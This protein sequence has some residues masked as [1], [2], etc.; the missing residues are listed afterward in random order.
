MRRTLKEAPAF[1]AEIENGG[2]DRKKRPLWLRA[3][4]AGGLIFLF[5]ILFW[6]PA[7]AKVYADAAPARSYSI[8]SMNETD[9]V[10]M[11]GDGK[12]YLDDWSGASGQYFRFEKC[13]VGEVNGYRIVSAATGKAMA[14][15]SVYARS[16]VFPT[17]RRNDI[18]QVWLVQYMRNGSVE[19]LCAA[20]RKYVLSIKGG[21]T[22]PGTELVLLKNNHKAYQQWTIAPGT[23]TS[24]TIGS[25]HRT[26]TV[27]AVFTRILPSDDGRIY[28]VALPPYAA[29]PRSG[30]IVASVKAASAVTIKGDLGAGTEA[31]LLQKKFL[32][33]RKFKGFY[34]SI[35]NGFFLT[36]PENAATNQKAF[37]TAA[38]KK[39]L[40]LMLNDP[41]INIAK[42]LRV[43]HAVVDFPIEAFLS[44]DSYS[45]VYEGR[46]YRFSHA[47][48]AGQAEHLRQ[49]HENGVVVTGVFYLTNKTMTDCILPSAVSGSRFQN[50]T[51]CALNTANA[52]RKRLEAL[53]S[54]L[55]EEFT[56]K[57]ILVANWVYGNEENNY[58]VYHYAG[59]VSYFR[60]HDALA[61][62]FRLFN[63]A[64]KSKWKNARTYF[65]LDHNWN[66]WF[67]VPGSYQGMALTADFH[68]D[69]AGEGAVHWD[70]A[71]HPYPSP[72]MDCR[73]WNRTAF[74]TDSGSSGQITMANARAFA[75]YIKK[76]YGK[77]T[78]IIMS[79]TGICALDQDGTNRVNDQAA[80]VALAYYLTEFDSNIDMI[81][82]HREMDEAGSAWHLGLY[83]FDGLAFARSSARPAALVFAYMDTSKWEKYVGK[84]IR[85]TGFKDWPTFVRSFGLTFTESKFKGI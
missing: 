54:C 83:E 77:S 25:N 15:R 33:A 73:F 67:E 48:I 36:N 23:I 80:A 45:Y 22:D 50:A 28:L 69:L 32:L 8:R 20:N 72:E 5:C 13:R 12:F 30:R 2:T 68:K 44:G 41:C 37:P 51:I 29:S 34:F 66:L 17:A 81:G 1:S 4:A 9:R 63:T 24:A 3:F 16:P 35:S 27:K 43:S 38:T 56:K 6:M 85:R 55:A 79:E 58:N 64:V 71:M 74:V 60:Y 46:S 7:Q 61:D 26:V 31:S 57:E 10:F 76:T 70:L 21:S 19:F 65:S 62:G 42:T 39:G 52:G 47:A 49:L 75:E 82:I 78:H 53:F 14:V 11:T 59:D 84:Y 18:G 40:K